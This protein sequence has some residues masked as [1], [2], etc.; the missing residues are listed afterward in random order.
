MKTKAKH[1][2][3]RNVALI[4]EQLVRYISRSLIEGKN[5]K[6]R[7][8]MGIVKEHFNKDSNLYREFRLF[9]A[10]LRTT[11][12]DEKLATRILDEAR[13]AARK[14][15]IKALDTE[16][17]RLISSINKELNESNFFDA[18]VPEY[19]DLA[20]IQTLLNEWR[21]GDDA[22]IPVIVEFEGKAIEL[23]MTPK[24]IPELIKAENVNCLSVKLMREKVANKFGQDLSES[25]LRLVMS[26]ARGDITTARS[27]MSENKTSSLQALRKFASENK[28]E[29]LSEKIG[30]V[31][32]SVKVLDVNDVSE[33]NVAKFLL[34][35]KLTEELLGGD[36]AK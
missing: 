20:T 19:R 30:S 29:V 8:A 1:N 27:I 23:L 24:K 25:Q 21:K 13:Q 6:A 32:E 11:V 26:S 3:K 16:K 10:M 4:Y 5:D 35:S 18:R 34:L 2:K 12:S 22:N 17:G 9:N 36:D 15:G 14:H 33:A 31:L 7:A 28:N